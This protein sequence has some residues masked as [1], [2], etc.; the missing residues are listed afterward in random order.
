MGTE[1]SKYAYRAN[2]ARQLV[3]I[4]G[5]T[6]KIKGI[7]DGCTEDI[8]AAVASM[9]GDEGYF[10]TSVQKEV[11]DIQAKVAAIKTVVDANQ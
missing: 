5:H 7:V 8:V 6:A 1:I 10:D 2:A 9:K 3:S 4:Q 11:T